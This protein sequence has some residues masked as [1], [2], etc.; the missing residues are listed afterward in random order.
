M[1]F[2]FSFFY[3]LFIFRLSDWLGMPSPPGHANLVQ[4]MLTLKLAGLAFE[5]NSA[6][7]S[8]ADDPQGASSAALAR[9]SFLDVFHYAFSYI[10]VLT[11]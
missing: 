11:G 9:I 10:G 4:M 5:L 2:F 7:T 3:L 6:A 1:C 8:P